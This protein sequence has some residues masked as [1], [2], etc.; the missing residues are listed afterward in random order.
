MAKE[1]RD[2]HPD[3][4]DGSGKAMQLMGF[5]RSDFP[6]DESMAKEVLSDRAR[7]LTMDFHPDAGGTTESFQALDKA[8]DIIREWIEDG[9]PFYDRQY[10]DDYTKEKDEKREQ[11]SRR[12]SY[13]TSRNQRVSQ[14]RDAIKLTFAE[15]IL[16]RNLV[17]YD[18][19]KEARQDGAITDEDVEEMQE[20]LYERFGENADLDTL[21]DVLA[22]LVTSGSMDM[23]DVERMAQEGGFF[24]GSGG[25]F[26]GSNEGFFSGSNE[27]FFSGDSDNF[28]SGDDDNFFQ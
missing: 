25:F 11:Y 20:R 15:T 4:V 6:D 14:I 18:T 8:R 19:W 17:E 7:D 21:T 22:M 10:R 12:R 23:G 26:S 24:T 28:F 13:S 5:D 2:W 27:G 3:D 9:K 1:P 16:E